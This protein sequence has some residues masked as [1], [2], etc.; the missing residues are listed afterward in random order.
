MKTS[1]TTSSMPTS[2]NRWTQKRSSTITQG[3]RNSSRKTFSDTRKQS[4]AKKIARFLG[5]NR[6]KIKGRYLESICSDSGVCL[7]FGNNASAIKDFFNGFTSLKYAISPMTQID[8]EIEE[9]FIQERTLTLNNTGDLR[10]YPV[11]SSNRI[12]HEIKYS[13]ENYLAH[14]IVKSS[15]N[16][17]AVNLFYE[18]IVGL[19]INEK[20][21]L[22]PCFLETYGLFIYKDEDAWTDTNTKKEIEIICGICHEVLN[23]K[24][25]PG[26]S[27]NCTSQCNDAIRV[28][29]NG[30]I[31]HR[32]CILE[33]SS[34]SMRTRDQCP[35]CRGSCLPNLDTVPKVSNR[36]LE[37]KNPIQNIKD[38]GDFKRNTTFLH[39]DT[40]LSHHQFKELLAISCRSPKHIAVMIQHIKNAKTIRRVIIDSRMKDIAD[41][42]NGSSY[43]FY[44][45]ELVNILFQIYYP[46][47]EMKNVFTHYDLRMNN[48]ILYQPFENGHIDFHYQTTPTTFI[49]FRS[50]YISKIVDYRFSYFKQVKPYTRTLTSKISNFGRSQ[51]Y[52]QDDINSMKIYKLLC[53]EPAC[54]PRCGDTQGYRKLKPPTRSSST[55][56]SSSHYN[57]LI[58][59]SVRNTGFDLLLLNELKLFHNYMNGTFTDL[60]GDM[61]GVQEARDILQQMMEFK[62]FKAVNIVRYVNSTKMGDLYIYNDGRPM[63]Y[64]ELE[65]TQ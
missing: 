62:E 48:V 61:T 50:K 64:K 49:T 42:N 39:G 38:I 4:A 46:L 10:L 34:T 65:S 53:D 21:K 59:S 30:H 56:R 28:C 5:K 57:N 40:A 17:D 9:E 8:K 44:Y 2:S 27:S 7:A 54:N 23:N 15:A 32:G 12:I 41:G 26:N 13:R 6:M 33:W 24:S 25:G 55:R 60:F 18:Y 47:S 3:P 43:D 63:E 37:S 1:K 22:Y 36:F 20:N 31:F 45:Y 35:E 14:S 51:T 58:H 11:Y 29:N 19:F 16:T 52:K